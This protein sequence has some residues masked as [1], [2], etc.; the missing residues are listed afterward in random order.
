MFDEPSRALPHPGISNSRYDLLRTAGRVG[1]VLAC[2]WSHAGT[3][4]AQ[5]WL[6]DAFRWFR[7]YGDDIG[8]RIT[9]KQFTNTARM[10][11]NIRTVED[12]AAT[13]EGVSVRRLNAAVQDLPFEP[14][15]EGLKLSAAASEAHC[16]G[17]KLELQTGRSTTYSEYITFL[18]VHYA[19]NQIPEP[20]AMEL[21]DLAQSLMRR[22]VAIYALTIG[23]PV[24]YK[25]RVVRACSMF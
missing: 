4:N 11:R 7:T 3:A 2:L 5:A 1:L 15:T 21:R 23:D 22:A 16:E 12:V 20:P 18:I 10:S 25:A 14:V 17:L 6:D 24:A 9:Q 8:V 19:R 13:G